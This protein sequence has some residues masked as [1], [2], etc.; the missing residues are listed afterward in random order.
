[1]KKIIKNEIKN[2]IPSKNF[3][4]LNLV[5]VRIDGIDYFPKHLYLDL[6]KKNNSIKI[7]E[8]GKYRGFISNNTNEVF[9]FFKLTNIQLANRS[10][11]YFNITRLKGRCS[12]EIHLFNNVYIFATSVKGDEIIFHFKCFN[13]ES[14]T[15]LIGTSTISDTKN[16]NCWKTR[17]PEFKK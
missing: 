1:M 5:E 4:T 15:K 11:S 3:L 17:T 10:S 14:F 7:F 12:T 6:S 13:Y 2:N 9:G 16:N 8:Y